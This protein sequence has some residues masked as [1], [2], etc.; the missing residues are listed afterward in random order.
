[1]IFR[2]GN[3]CLIHL[4]GVDTIPTI[5]TALYTN[6]LLFGSN[7]VCGITSVSVCPPVSVLQPRQVFPCVFLSCKANARV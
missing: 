6:E 7:S 3:V 5:H 1:V 2:P 4:R